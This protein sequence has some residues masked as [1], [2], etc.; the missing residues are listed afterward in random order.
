MKR[1]ISL[2]NLGMSIK[3]APKFNSEDMKKLLIGL[4]SLIMVIAFSTNVSAQESFGNAGLEIALPVGD[5]AEDTY[6]IGI[7]GSGGYEFGISDNFAVNANVG[8][9]FLS[10]NSDVSDFI[11]SSF[12]VPVQL[13]GRYYIS[14]SREGLF[15]EGKV[16]MHL[17][18]TTTEDFESGGITVEGES[19][20]EAYFSFAP[21]V[22]YFIN[23]N[24]S[25]ALRYQIAVV[26]DEDVE[27]VN[28]ITGETMT[29][30]V[31]GD[32]IGYIGLKAAYNF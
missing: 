28:P 5:W 13:G 16:G 3:F 27:T 7:G 10:I 15:V 32:N 8:I 19:E 30:T 2:A 29:T 22:G 4:A 31:E 20:S 11:A 25:V 26:G 9:V 18:S 14:E 21:Q 23:E 12:M 6:G 1:F 17:F 24:L